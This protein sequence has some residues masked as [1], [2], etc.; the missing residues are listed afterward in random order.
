MKLHFYWRLTFLTTNCSTNTK[1]FLVLFSSLFLFACQVTD[2]FSIDK[3]IEKQ[4]VDYAQYYL[5]IKGLT[6]NELVDEIN[7]QK[8]NKLDNQA[9]ADIHL[10]LL[11]SLPNSPIHNPYTAKALLNAQQK[12]NN[13]SSYVPADI[14]FVALLKDQL[15]QQLFLFQQL[16]GEDLAQEQ[17]KTKQ[18]HA[19]SELEEKIKQLEKQ[20]LQLKNIEKNI[21]EHGQ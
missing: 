11:H 1:L 5:Y 21:S 3:S 16:I 4:R 12:K 20:I 18:H 7:Q 13:H 2:Q 8:L 10:L 19:L 17:A 15:N 9:K 6:S 14:A